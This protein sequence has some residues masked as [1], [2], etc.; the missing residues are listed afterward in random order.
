MNK[1]YEEYKIINVNEIEG[2]RVHIKD[3]RIKD[4]II[5]AE[6]NIIR[7][8]FKSPFE[9]VKTGNKYRITAGRIHFIAAKNMGYEEVPCLVRNRAK[10]AILFK[11]LKKYSLNVYKK[12]SS[13]FYFVCLK[14]EKN[15]QFFY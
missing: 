13:I 8:G 4:A 10:E 12:C 2:A 7:Y 5:R 1:V 15:S 6:N 3:K 11:L 9:V 14:V